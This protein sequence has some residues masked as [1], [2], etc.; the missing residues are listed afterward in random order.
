ML[1]LHPL[2]PTWVRCSICL[3]F[4]GA[5]SFPVKSVRLMLQGPFQVPKLLICLF[6]FKIPCIYL[7]ALCGLRDLNSPSRG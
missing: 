6:M 4:C 7:A 1:T 3:R 5:E 2:V